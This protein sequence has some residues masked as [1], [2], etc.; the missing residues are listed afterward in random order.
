MRLSQ[1]KLNGSPIPT[2][3]TLVSTQWFGSS[4]SNP[5]SMIR[6]KSG[7]LMVAWNDE[8]PWPYSKPDGSVDTGF[9]YRS[10]TGNWTVKFPITIPT[11]L[12]TNLTQSTMTMAQHPADGSIWA[13][14]KRDAAAQL[15]EQG[16][17][18]IRLERYSGMLNIVTSFW[19]SIRIARRVRRRSE[20]W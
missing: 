2:S 11:P 3:A 14:S 5:K 13:F 18:A 19:R 8:M 7:A 17:R 4:H 10:S 9:A 15:E 12:A 1:Y 16:L 20:K 6:L